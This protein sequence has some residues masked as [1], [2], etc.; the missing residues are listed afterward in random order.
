ME[1]EL[2]PLK[3]FCSSADAILVNIAD[4]VIAKVSEMLVNLKSLDTY[5]QTLLETAPAKI[6]PAVA[7]NL[8][9]Y[10]LQLTDKDL[11][12]KEKLQA[13][14][15][16][17]KAKTN[18]KSEK[19]LI[20]MIQDYNLSPFNN[21]KST[22]FLD[23]RSLEIKALKML[24]ENLDSSTQDNFEIADYKNPNQ[25]SLLLKYRKTVKFSINILQSESVTKAFLSGKNS[26]ASAAFW[27]NDDAKASALGHQKDLFKNF[28]I[29]NKYSKEVGYLISINTRNEAKPIE[30]HARKFGKQV[31][32][33]DFIIPSYPEKPKFVSRADDQFTVGVKNPHNPWVTRYY[34][35]YWRLVDGVDQSTRV[36]F[37]FSDS[38]INNATISNLKPLT[39]YEYKIVY[40][41]EFGVSPSSEINKVTTT[42][43]TEPKNIRLG[44]VTKNSL[45]ILWNIPV[46]GAGVKIN[47]YKILLSGM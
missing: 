19:D 18:G 39:T 25:A 24:M 26:T 6:Y 3:E 14:L 40:S 13:L 36:E 7:S 17:V 30:M 10:R 37:K 4:S 41:T 46:C 9:H 33:G 34:V 15:P 16:A 1:I 29:A 12:I 45:E 35:D 8:N 31:G 44:M 5:V 28:T 21:I 22:I 20:N 38:D 2:T 11:K 27:Y 42:P 47:T 23:S 32:S 43:C